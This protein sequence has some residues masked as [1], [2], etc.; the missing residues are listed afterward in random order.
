VLVAFVLIWNV[1]HALWAVP[2]FRALYRTSNDVPTSL[3]KLAQVVLVLLAMM[4]LR[5][6]GPRGALGELG[7]DSRVAQG[8]GVVFLALL[9]TMAGFA[10]LNG[11]NVNFAPMPFVRTALASPFSEEMLFRGLLF[12]QLHQRAGWP[13]WAAVLVNAVPF[14]WG[15]LYQA[16][17]GDWLGTIAVLAVTGIGAAYSAWLFMRWEWNLWVVIGFHAYLNAAAYA[18]DIGDSVLTKASTLPLLVL[19]L[20]TTTLVTRR[21][22]RRREA[23]PAPVGAP[24]PAL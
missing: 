3:W 9:P 20:L 15:H 14:A 22:A 4:A 18:F 11:V 6:T 10:V 5:R 17:S 24:A 7:M 16:Q 2:D 21:Y 8:L 13:F 12:R 1:R 23:P 19:G